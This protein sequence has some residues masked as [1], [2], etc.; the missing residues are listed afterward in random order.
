[1]QNLVCVSGSIFMKGS[2][3]VV[4]VKNLFE[5]AK[6]KK[7]K[8]PFLK[9]IPNPF[10]FFNYFLA[11]ILK[12]SFTEITPSQFAELYNTS[13]SDEFAFSYITPEFLEWR[14]KPFKHYYKGIK[15][16]ANQNGDYYAGFAHDSIYYICDFHSKSRFGIF[17]IIRHIFSHTS[18]KEINMIR[19]MD[20]VV[21]KP[22][23]MI[24]FGFVPFGT[25]SEVYYISQDQ[26]VLDAMKGKR[27]YYS[28]LDSDENI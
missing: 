11:K 21:D 1:M 12:Q 5:V 25:I 23:W 27:F 3:K 14:F 2:W 13:K 10:Y 8:Y 7:H 20:N 22:N 6:I 17:K 24:K 16:F 19:F 9:L 28:Y 15:S 18:F 4:F 26:E